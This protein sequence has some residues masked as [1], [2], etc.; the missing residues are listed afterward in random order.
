MAT[1]TSDPTSLRPSAAGAERA[2]THLFVVGDRFEG[3]VHDD[4]V[5]TVTKLCSAICCGAFD[6]LNGRVLLHRGQGITAFDVAYVEAALVR[7]GLQDRARFVGAEQ[8]IASRDVA[9]KHRP[10]NVLLAD[11]RR[12]GLQTFRAD[13]RVHAGN[14]LLLD[15]QTGEHLQGM[16]VVEAARQ[17]FLAAFELGY[18]QRWPLHSFCVSW[19]SMQM[20]FESFLFPLPAQIVGEL[21]EVDV[22]SPKRLRFELGFELHQLGRRVA[23]GE[24]GF[25]SFEAGRL[26]AVERRSADKA[27]DAA[28]AFAAASVEAAD[29]ASLAA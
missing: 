23:A 1:T 5:R 10:E 29:P 8:A 6:E 2:P 15:H 17:M 9:H 22:R 3:F 25:A 27:L 13:L 4:R 20:T 21:R 19:N 28:V 18:R 14:E 24:I 26:S 7:R 16:V 12:S 11:L